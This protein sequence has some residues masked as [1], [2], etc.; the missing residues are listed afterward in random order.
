MVL[1][2][3]LEAIPGRTLVFGNGNLEITGLEYDSRRVR[4]GQVFFA[5]RGLKQ[6]GARFIPEALS[7]GAVAVVSEAPPDSVPNERLPAWICT[8]NTR[9]AMALAARVYYG[10]PSSQMKLFGITGTNGKTT[11]AFLLASILQSSGWRPGLF[12]TIEYDIEFGG[13]PI[14]SHLS[15]P[16]TTPESLDLQR[17]LR[18]VVDHGGRSAVME[19]S[20][21]ALALDR[22]EGCSFYTAVF[23][24]LSRDHLD[25]HNDMESYFA[26]KQKLFAGSASAPPPTYAVL[27]ADDARCSSL[28][29]STPTQ[30]LT[31]GMSAP[32]DVIA[33]Q[34]STGKS[35]IEAVL[36]TP[37]GTVEVQSPL[38]GR[39][40]VYNLMA[41][42]TAALTLDIAPQKI[43]EAVSRLRVPGRVESIDEG[44]PFRV[45][46]DY[47][48][49][50][51]ALRNLLQSAREW[52]A[53][54]VI[55]VFGCGGERDR[56]KRPLMGMAAAAADKTVLTS[57]NPRGEDPIA[58]LNDVIVGLQKS[59]AIYDVQGDRQRAIEMAILDAR[60]GDT[61]L[62]AGKGHETY[63]IIGNQKLPF[64]DRETARAVL[65]KLG[66]DKTP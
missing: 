34:W 51:D 33:R 28:R 53:G 48:H 57:D 26:A 25:F 60:P 2:Q 15:A 24:N 35:G 47:A 13:E 19:V 42:T 14:L 54:R 49:T 63:Q 55:L 59:K 64:D 4:P 41:A 11:V 6:D 23:T 17:L 65:R 27:N 9:V 1:Q 45:V 66:F 36:E 3:L 18:A 50:D 62:I 32:A 43:S 5:I 29:A 31:Y 61:V 8:P 40:N 58:I 44:Q 7:R 21:H 20:S 39:H 38:L 12:G 16:N 37:C 56:T 22:V 52:S 46:V 30:V 10:N